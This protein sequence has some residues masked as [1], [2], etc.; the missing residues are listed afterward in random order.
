MAGAR[1]EGGS[2]LGGNGRG[3]G[4]GVNGGG[5]G[6]GASG[7]SEGGCGAGY[8]TTQGMTDTA[9][10]CDAQS[11]GAVYTHGQVVLTPVGAS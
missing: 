6:T 11:G 3:G 2:G 9:V 8:S 7:T 5:P 10:T 1:G 4:G